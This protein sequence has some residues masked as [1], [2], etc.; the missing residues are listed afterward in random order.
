MAFPSF[1]KKEFITICVLC[2]VW[3]V[4][5]KRRNTND[6]TPPPLTD[7]KVWVT[8]L[9]GVK[10]WIKGFINENMSPVLKTLIV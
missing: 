8:P 10:V 9:T 5:E 1:L 2:N 7:V 3:L 6:S 4:L